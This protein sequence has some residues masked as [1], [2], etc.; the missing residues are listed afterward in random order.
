MMEK[1]FSVSAPQVFC[2]VFFYL[3]SGMMLFCGG[4]FTSALFA[5]LFCACLCTV[6][7][8]FCRNSF[9]SLGF[10]GAVFGKFGAVFR[11]IAAFCATLSLVRTLGAFSGEASRFYGGGDTRF[12]APVAVLLCVLAV[13][14]GFVRAARL[15]E[16]CAFP[17]LLALLLSL[18]GGGGEG[19]SFSF[20]EDVLF[21]GFDVIGAAPAFFTLYLRNVTVKSGEMSDFAK[22]S[23]FQPSA[24]ASG[25]F[26]VVAALG[27]YAFFSYAAA[28][29]IMLSLFAWFF[30]LSRLSFL[31]M[32][33]ADLLAFPENG[34][35]VKT[36]F[37]T[38]T[39]CSFW[40]IFASFL[41]NAA[42]IAG[43]FAAVLFPCT[44]FVLYAVKNF[45]SAN[46]AKSGE[47]T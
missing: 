24:L 14:K 17:F 12:F 30:T 16:T 29:N 20:G 40:L 13:A 21:S 22:N 36:V 47:K 15:A 19:L 39:F 25:L 9:S 35:G 38:V 34:N 26:A 41:P 42:K 43:V 4:S 32:T 18:L 37:L 46:I 6:A 28:D 10:Y 2:L 8:S 5:A 33:M 1:K 7:A 3:L 31:S 44:V 27:A 23:S 11:Y 45:G